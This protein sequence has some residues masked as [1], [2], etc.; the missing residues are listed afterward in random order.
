MPKQ[1]T[2]AERRNH[3]AEVESR[4]ES[5]ANTAEKPEKTEKPKSLSVKVRRFDD[6]DDYD[7][8]ETAD[9]F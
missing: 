7:W 8:A 9:D 3:K 5:K 1:I 6:I 4:K 2:K